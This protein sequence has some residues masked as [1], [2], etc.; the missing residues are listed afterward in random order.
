M[1]RDRERREYAV[2]LAPYLIGIAV[3]IALPTLVTLALA[4]HRVR[5]HPAHASS[6]SRTSAISGATRSFQVSATR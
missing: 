6:A 5:P 4:A 3:L 2:M 1:L